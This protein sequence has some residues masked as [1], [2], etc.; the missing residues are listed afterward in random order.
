MLNNLSHK[1]KDEIII[2]LWEEKKRLEAENEALK[3]KASGIAV[4]KKTSENSSIPPSKDQ[5]ANKGSSKRS[6]RKPRIEGNQ[7]RRLDPNPTQTVVARAKTCPHCGEAV[8]E[9]TIG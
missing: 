3:S 2:S 1:E 7:D 5:K 8:G 4:P 6:K 9:R